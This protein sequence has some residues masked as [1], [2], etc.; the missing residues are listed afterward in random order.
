LPPTLS[1]QKGNRSQATTTGSSFR[2]VDDRNKLPV[3]FR[4]GIGAFSRGVS[5]EALVQGGRR[6]SG[7]ARAAHWEN[8]GQVMKF[9]FDL[10]VGDRVI[11]ITDEAETQTEF[12]QKM[13]FWDT[14]P[15]AGPN[16]EA[17]LKFTYRTPKGYEYYSIACPDAGVEF[18]FG[19][20][21]EKKKCLFPKT[22][23]PIL[24]GVEH[25]EEADPQP[26]T[27][28]PKSGAKKQETKQS[29]PDPVASVKQNDDVDLDERAKRFVKEKRVSKA[30]D[31][32]FKVKVNEKVTYSIWRDE[33]NRVKCECE[34][35]KKGVADDGTFRC[36]H[37]RAIK[38]Y[39]VPNTQSAAA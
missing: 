28:P 12:F 27:E 9:E 23:E 22:W 29:K 17:E 36:E 39:L 26:A 33:T 6:V 1:D 24:H 2:H 35:F 14:I 32:T 38:L 31:G 34:R 11:R 7:K 16:G 30:P 3:V 4:R 21:K 10:R 25:H 20:F 37:I 18:K 8:G 13:A 5:V 19:E 15:N